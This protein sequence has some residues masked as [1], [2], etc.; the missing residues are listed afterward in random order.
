MS[1][2]VSPNAGIIPLDAKSFPLSVTIHS[3]VKGPAKGSVKLSL[4]PGWKSDSP[5]AVFQT[6][7]DGENQA[8]SFHVEPAGLKNA[9]YTINAIANYA[10]RDYREG[11]AIAG[12]PG[13]RPYFLY[14]GS[15]YKATGTDVAVAPNL[16][17]GYVTGSGDDVPATLGELGLGMSFLTARDVAGANLSQYDVILL[18]VRAYA[19]RPELAIY[20]TRLLDYVKNG[21][22]LIVQYNTPEFDHNFGPY[23]YTMGNEPEEVVDEASDVQILDPANPLFNWPNK[24]TKADFHGWVEERGSKFLTSWDKRYSALLETHDPGQAP[25][26]GGLL[27]ARYGKGAYIYNAYAF[28]RELPEGVPGAFRLMANMLSLPRN[29]QR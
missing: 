14:R 3:N 15:E 16:K 27:F 1:I 8:L 13:L 29:P 23:P 22:V 19:A 26:K 11:Y 4:P 12:Y 17:I 28:Y 20:N 24:I 18:G 10:G 2:Q 7:Q 21:G 6:S 5:L 9:A 25:Q